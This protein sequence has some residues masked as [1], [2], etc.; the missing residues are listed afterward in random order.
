MH[1][2]S[3][4]IEKKINYHFLYFVI[5]IMLKITFLVF[6]KWFLK[7]F[8]WTFYFY[9]FLLQFESDMHTKEVQIIKT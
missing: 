8:K 9:V 4:S 3:L 2:C 5:V 6:K 7:V 1:Q